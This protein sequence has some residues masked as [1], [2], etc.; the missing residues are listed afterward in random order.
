MEG[1]PGL[2]ARCQDLAIPIGLSHRAATSSLR[3]VEEA[4]PP[5]AGAAGNR[6]YGD[7]PDLGSGQAR[8]D[9]FQLAACAWG[10]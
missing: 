2:L 4:R 3:C 6:V 1:A 9:A 8:P 5:L 10:Q 7:D